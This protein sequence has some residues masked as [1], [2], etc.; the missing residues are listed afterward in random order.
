MFR[1]GPMP[2]SSCPYGLFPQ[3]TRKLYA[4]SK[5][6]LMM[7]VAESIHFKLLSRLPGIP[8]DRSVMEALPG[9]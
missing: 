8:H 9:A 6:T 7:G 1:Y 3:S 4:I 2:A 5:K